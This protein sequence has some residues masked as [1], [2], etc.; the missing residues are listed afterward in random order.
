MVHSANFPTPDGHRPTAEYGNIMVL[1]ERGNIP[2][3]AIHTTTAKRGGGLGLI[4]VVA[5]CM[6]LCG[7]WKSEEGGKV[8]SRLIGS[9]GSD[10]MKKKIE[11][12]IYKGDPDEIGI[13]PSI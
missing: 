7:E 5:K 3:P 8:H 2:F 9:Q 4:H 1:M 11:T 12:S 10:Y 6:T 13:P